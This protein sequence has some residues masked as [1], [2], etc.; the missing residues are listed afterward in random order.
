VSWELGAGS[1]EL[2]VRSWGKRGEFLG[3]K[4]MVEGWGKR[5]KSV[6]GD[7]GNRGGRGR[8]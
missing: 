2:G 6:I 3:R 7:R 5:Q 1:W 4:S 8:D